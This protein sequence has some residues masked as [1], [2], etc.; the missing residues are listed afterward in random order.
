MG[1]LE[2]KGLTMKHKQDTIE[3]YEDIENVYD[4]DFIEYEF[5]DQLTEWRENE[6]SSDY[7]SRN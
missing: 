5:E 6:Q 2:I 1:T 3:T 4:Q 7:C